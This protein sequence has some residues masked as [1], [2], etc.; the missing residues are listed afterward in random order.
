MLRAMLR[1]LRA[2]VGRVAM[3]LIAIVLGVGFVV[4][5]WVVSDSAAA[6][7]ANGTSRSDLAVQVT[8]HQ[9]DV[10]L[11]EQQ[12]Q[13]LA[14]L[15][16]VTGAAGVTSG[17]AALVNRDGKLDGSHLPEAGG[18]NWDS[19]QRFTL[20][21]GRAPTGGD[22]VALEETAAKDSGLAIGSSARILLANQ[23]F[24]TAT[25][26]GI[27]TYRNTG[28][29]WTP[30]LAYDAATASARLG[31]GYERI[32]LFGTDQAAIA[33]AVASSAT[34]DGSQYIVDTGAQL[35]A[36]AT[37]DADDSASAVRNFLLAFAGVALLVGMFVIANTF[38]MLVAQRTRQFALLRAVGAHRG[39]VRRALLGEATVLGGVGA[40]LGVGLGIGLAAVTMAVLR[41][42]GETILFVVS[43]AAVIVGLA[44][45][46]VVTVV[47]AYGSARRA[48]RIAPVAALRTDAALP[49]RSLVVR[50]VLGCVA[51]I[52]G[53]LLV[54]LASRGE[55]TDGKRM[56]AMGGAL[57]A[58][59][60]LLLLAP[61]LVSAVLR[62]LAR[63]AARRSGP[64]VKLALRNAI[65]DPRRTAATASALMI[66]L[67]LVC[68]FATVGE[69]LS[70]GTEEGISDTVPSRT[71]VIQPALPG[72]EVDQA[73]LATMDALPDVDFLTAP[74]VTYG[75]L[76]HGSNTMGQRITGLDPAALGRVVT[77]SLVTGRA[78]LTTGALVSRSTA[79]T[80][81]LRVGDQFTIDLHQGGLITVAVS[82][83]YGL[84][85]LM[86]GVIIDPVRLPADYRVNVDSAFATGA[87]P[88]AT[89][90]ALDAALA[91]RPDLVVLDRDQLID[92][93][94]RP[95][96][97]ALGIIYALLGAAILI[98]IF[99][100]VNTLALSVL[101][102]TREIGVLR[103]IGAS[104]RF[105]GRSVRVES[106]VIAGYG[107]LLGVGVGLL[108]GGVMQHVLLGLP[109]LDFVVPYPVVVTALVGMVV[110][111]VVAALWPARRASRTDVLTAIAVE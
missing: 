104:R 32:E 39:Q 63:L 109:I 75:D 4:A 88:A 72:G 24:D 9:P 33:A 91:G 97:L 65:R 83:I 44:V 86:G 96:R 110:I 52:A 11:T 36:R 102:R 16:A 26:V 106:V 81:G 57:L 92:Q 89:R 101:E 31:E 40:I 22:E 55:L 37:A 93:A 108:L 43:P 8:S 95:V 41:D 58:W 14:A 94:V 74:T 49:R 54:V 69:T 20:V 111:G 53:V 103:A 6:T 50:T 99:G 66:S 78:D 79:D 64:T 98:S 35:T 67:A 25:V 71:F 17:F 15:P 73:T 46:V 105:V 85:Q 7:V 29:E 47:A 68:A 42:T 61:V 76:Q 56:T 70:S 1:D 23:R 62:P 5:T 27:F 28:L 21:R 107:G 2:H 38:T 90:A 10:L 100:V 3:T 30:A 19:S 51:T 87:N 80:L 59:L 84:N 45:G 60:G 82:G 34:V 12:R 18:T 77:I 48:A 13:R